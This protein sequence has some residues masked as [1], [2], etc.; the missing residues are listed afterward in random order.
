MRITIVGFLT[1]HKS[2]V[3]LRQTIATS[4][5]PISHSLAIG[6]LP[7]DTLVNAFRADTG[8]IVMPVRLVG[9][10][11]SQD[12]GNGLSLTYRCIQ[13]GGAL[14]TPHGGPTAGYFD[15]TPPPN[16]LGDHHR[17]QLADAVQHAGGPPRLAEQTTTLGARLRRRVGR[18][19]AT[20]AGPEWAATARLVVVGEGGVHWVR[21][22]AG[23][24]RLPGAPVAAGDTPW[25]AARRVC[26]GAAAGDALALRL[27][28]MAGASPALSFVFVAPADAAASGPE[29]V[30]LVR[31]IEAAGGDDFDPADVGLA[32]AALAEAATLVRLDL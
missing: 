17:R 25:A 31:P 28:Q 16:G 11:H 5:A 13:R 23:R 29:A 26:P 3:L 22:A 30:R 19:A 8:L 12:A 32:R 21:D 27:I 7:T 14:A 20:D 6:Q 24:W 9:V 15:S 2:R 1:D 10:Y 18:R 4:L